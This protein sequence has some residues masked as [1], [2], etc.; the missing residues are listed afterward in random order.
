MHYAIVDFLID[1][2]QNSCEA[3]AELVKIRLD[4]DEAG[5]EITVSDNGKGM[6][7]RELERS[8]DPFVTDG[9][10]HPGR[11]VGL[12]L[13]FLKQAAEQGGG[14]FSI[15]SEKGRGTE[16][17]FRFDKRNLDCPPLGDLPGALLSVL[18]MPGARE[19][20]IFRRRGLYS[21]ELRKS[22][23]VDAL[24]S[25]EEVASLALLKHYLQSQEEG[26]ELW[27]G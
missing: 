7:E 16:V 18:C 23:L 10:K 12:G 5:I 15:V 21:Y 27:Q 6:T 17:A 9:K 2:A 3:G 20:K 4:E 14:H 1:I 8:I 13:P 24:G 25:L 11:K 19:I 22:E 26:E